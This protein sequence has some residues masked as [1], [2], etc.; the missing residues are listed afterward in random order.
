MVELEVNGIFLNILN[1]HLSSKNI[2]NR[3]RQ[4]KEILQKYNTSE[5]SNKG[6][7]FIITGDLNTRIG[8]NYE[9][10]GI[11][12]LNYYKSGHILKNFMRGCFSMLEQES[13]FEIKNF[14][15]QSCRELIDFIEENNELRVFTSMP[16]QIS[17]DEHLYIEEIDKIRFKPSFCYDKNK[18]Y[19]NHNFV[20]I[21]H[22]DC[23]KLTEN[24]LSWPDRILTVNNKIFETNRN[25]ID[26]K[27]YDMM[28]LPLSDHMPVLS[29]FRLNKTQNTEEEQLMENGDKLDEILS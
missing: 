11:T 3:R 18:M 12:A 23:Y 5:N 1:V 10:D 27:F 29:Y 2:E 9:L 15:P 17:Q 20:E 7:A 14:S 21:Y 8:S 24:T 13:S 25:K 28:Y 22:N 6:A 19:K 4:L 26:V 16:F